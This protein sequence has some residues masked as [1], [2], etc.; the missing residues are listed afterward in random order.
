MPETPHGGNAPCLTRAKQNGEQARTILARYERTCRAFKVLR[1]RRGSRWFETTPFHGGN[2]GSN[3]LG[4]A[5]ISISYVAIPSRC[6]R[7]ATRITPRI[8]ARCPLSLHRTPRVDRAT[9]DDRA[10]RAAAVCRG[11][12]RRLSRRPTTSRS[13]ALLLPSLGECTKPL[14][15]VNARKIVEQ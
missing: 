11:S 6:G 5:K 3:P 12:P 2:R 15:V 4:D 8:A 9:D 13:H 14:G 10:A 7:G 1:V